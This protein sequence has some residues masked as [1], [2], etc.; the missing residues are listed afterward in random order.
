MTCRHTASLN[1]TVGDHYTVSG[2]I[3]TL[4]FHQLMLNLLFSHPKLT[5]EIRVYVKADGMMSE[6]QFGYLGTDTGRCDWKPRYVIGRLEGKYHVTALLDRIMQ[7][8]ANHG[9]I[10][11]SFNADAGRL[12]KYDPT[13]KHFVSVFKHK[14]N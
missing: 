14:S 3:L 12:Y 6:E 2:I 5:G 11:A 10:V 13:S 1:R 4:C 9:P 7:A 8:V